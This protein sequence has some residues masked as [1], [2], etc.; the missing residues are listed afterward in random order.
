M[1]KE[2]A[3]KMLATLDDTAVQI[4]TLAK[5]GKIDP[6]VASKIVRD[7]DSFADKF[8]VAAFG[9]QSLSNW[10]QKVS[11]VLKKDSDEKYMDSFENPIKTIKTD[12]DEEYMHTSGPSFNHKK[13]DTFD[14]DRSSSMTDRDEYL[15]REQ[16]DLAD[17]ASKQPS[18]TKGPA[19]K[20]TKQGSAPVKS[21]TKTWAP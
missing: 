16:S 5:S 19:G 3:N 8:Q 13:M 15:V 14:A 18:W 17:K 7:I 12:Q 10:K 21:A 6:K 1:K 9:E 4:E 11:K 2:I 20:S